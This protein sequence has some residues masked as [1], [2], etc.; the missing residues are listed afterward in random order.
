MHVP[1]LEAARPLV[2]LDEDGWAAFSKLGEAFWP[3]PL[4]L[5]VRASALIPPA[6]TAHTGSV[7]IRVPA[8][9]LARRLLQQA[10][11]PVAAPS[12]N[13]FGHV[14]PTRAA[15]VL[16]DLGDKGVHVR[17]A[18]LACLPLSQLSAACLLVS[19]P[20]CLRL[21]NALSLTL[22]THTRRY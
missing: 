17:T 15:H 8:H 5:I 20:P 9:D 13:R 3:G 11:V 12:A 4:T 7:G 18:L 14:S 1:E 16:A 10:Q 22:S 21:G 19:L 6:V 2:D